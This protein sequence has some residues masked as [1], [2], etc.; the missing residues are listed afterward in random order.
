MITTLPIIGQ[1]NFV[2]TWVLN[3]QYII[4]TNMFPKAQD[5]SSRGK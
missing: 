4:L 5:D 2:T 1:R 3:A